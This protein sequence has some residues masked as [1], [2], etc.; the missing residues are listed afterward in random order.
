MTRDARVAV[1]VGTRGRGSNMAALVR[2]GQKG[3][4]PAQVVLVVAPR[5]DTPALQTAADLGVPTAV[6]RGGADGYAEALVAALAAAEVDIVCLA[7]YMTL[8]PE[9]VL[10]NYPGRVLNVHP[11]LLPKF[12]GKGMYGH[13]VHEAVVAAGESES[14]CTVHLVTPVYD[15]GEVVVQLRCP[16]GPGDSPED[17]ASRVLELEHK[18]Y[19]MAVAE[20]WRRA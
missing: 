16:V 4:I 14:G 12:G 2:A 9:E 18:A 5:A 6:L 1:L 20:V 8:L 3:V 15:E 11:A 17:L 7:G 10:A 13:H 19:P